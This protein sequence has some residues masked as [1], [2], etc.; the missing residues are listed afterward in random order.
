MT[1][2]AAWMINGPAFAL[3]PDH[4]GTVLIVSTDSATATLLGA[5]AEVEGYHVTIHDD[6]RETPD[7][8]LK[9][10]R[11]EIILIDIDHPDGFAPEFLGV[12]REQGIAA[13]AFSPGRLTSEVL[14]RAEPYGLPMITLPIDPGAF[15]AVLR[16]ARG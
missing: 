7:N 3:A 6:A 13:V 16:R 1:G 4:M 2:K 8:A 14:E 12:L 15:G 9:R 11:P 10:S 5:F